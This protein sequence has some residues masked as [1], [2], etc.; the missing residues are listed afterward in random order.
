[1]LM[2]KYKC[3]DV[4]INTIGCVIGAHVGPGTL[5]LFFLNEALP[6]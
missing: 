6:F 4:I 2:E 5:A 1:M 3:K